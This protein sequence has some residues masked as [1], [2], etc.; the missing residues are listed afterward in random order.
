MLV[1]ERMHRCHQAWDFPPH[2][3]QGGCG[4]AIRSDL[5]HEIK[6]IVETLPQLGKQ[7]QIA[8]RP[9]LPIG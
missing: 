2:D 3:R 1:D 7:D 9:L 5:R 8:H 6:V 4:V